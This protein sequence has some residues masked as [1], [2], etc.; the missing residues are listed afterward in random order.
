MK[1]H[2]NATR[3]E[4][5]KLRK[6]LTIAVRGHKLLNDKLEGLMK[7]FLSM[8][9]R[10]KE[11]RELVDRKLPNIIGLFILAG[12]TSSKNNVVMA[13][14]QSKIT[15][16]FIP[17]Q[18]RVLNVPIPYLSAP[19]NQSLEKKDTNLLNTNNIISYSLLDTN[20]ELDNGITRLRDFFPNIIKLAELE[21]SVRAIAKEIGKTRK[22]VNALEFGIIPQIKENL[23]FIRNKLDEIERSNISRIMK[24][25]D[26][27]EKR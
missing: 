12:I 24:I 1:L 20:S 8:V 15:Y 5:L 19:L 16:N 11:Q 14:E 4:L 10:C 23:A 9:K 22:R 3:M 27:L 6:R 2:I 17:R 7:E 18:R 26:I 21:Q 13:L 25:K